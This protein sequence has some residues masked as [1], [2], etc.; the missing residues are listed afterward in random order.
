MSRF[1]SGSRLE[2]F[3]TGK[4]FYIVLFLC[5][6]VIGVSAWMLMAGNET[7]IKETDT[8]QA[9]F[10][11][12]VETV[13][14]PPETEQLQPVIKEDELIIEEAPE[15]KTEG[16]A[17][18]EA[19]PAEDVTAEEPAGET[20]ETFEE[21]AA[22]AAPTYIWPVTGQLER[23]HDGDK[24]RFDNTM[25]DWRSHEGIDILSTLGCPVEAVRAG[26]VISAEKDGL[27]G[28]TVKID[29]GDGVVSVYANLEEPAAVT[30]GQTV[31]AGD[32]VGSVGT[33]A[34]CES[35]QSSHLHFAIQVNGK[36]VNPLDY[37]PA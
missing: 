2:R 3:F 15:I 8:K 17:E 20:A 26:T 10:N 6:S 31:N 7:M 25:Q 34:I 1:D 27:Y 37:L 30:V 29:H 9:G 28:M 4:G 11:S 32:P 16:I 14:L 5:A 35:S 19:E 36:S 33:S 18:P 12:T 23:S 24:L 22:P 13:I 21:A